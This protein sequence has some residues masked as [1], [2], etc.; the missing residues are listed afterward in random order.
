MLV[1][2]KLPTSVE[3]FPNS[4]GRAACLL[5][6]YTTVSQL[7]SPCSIYSVFS[8]QLW[9]PCGASLFS[10]PLRSPTSGPFDWYHLRITPEKQQFQLLP[11]KAS[12]IMCLELGWNPLTNLFLLF[13][14]IS[15]PSL[16]TYSYCPTLPS[17]RNKML[18]FT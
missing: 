6:S 16:D 13:S 8:H 1:V 4:L 14:L 18:Y 5:W 3:A 7:Q 10:E 15:I 2:Q 11:T 9:S 17:S 12:K